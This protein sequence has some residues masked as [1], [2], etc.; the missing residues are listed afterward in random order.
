MAG[1][2]KLINEYNFTTDGA[3][4]VV[5]FTGLT[6]SNPYKLIITNLVSSSTTDV[7]PR[8]R[9]TKGGTAQTGSNYA[10]AGYYDYFHSGGSTTNNSSQ[11]FFDMGIASGYSAASHTTERS[12]GLSI[13]DIFGLTDSSTYDWILY[14]NNF[15]NWQGNGYINYLGGF[16]KVASASDGIHFFNDKGANMDNGTVSLYE[17]LG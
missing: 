12:W 8:I 14:K 11:T 16:H 13:V 6:S 2:L 15:T 4:S 1:K 7:K 5:E 9:V 3:A 10:Y 17:V